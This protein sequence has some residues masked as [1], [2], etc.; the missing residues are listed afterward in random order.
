MN[1]FVTIL[2]HELRRGLRDRA[3]PWILAVFAVLAAYGAWSGAIWTAERA[4]TVAQVRAEYDTSVARKMELLAKAPP[5]AAPF[6]LTPQ[7]TSF[8]IALDPGALSPLSIGQAEA[9]PYAARFQPLGDETLFDAFKVYVDNPAVRQAGRL[10][11]A[12]VLVVLAPLL[13]LAGCYDLWN[14]ERESGLSSLLLAQP[15]APGLLLAAKALARALLILTPMAGWSMAVLWMAQG[16]DAAGLLTL[17]LI[18]FVYGA[19]WVAVALVANLLTRRSTEAAI[20]CGAAWIALVAVGP[21][22]ALATVNLAAPPP[23]QARLANDMRAAAM[24]Y[25]AEIAPRVK[26]REAAPL[27]DPPPA[28][29]DRVRSF[30]SDRLTYQ[31]RMAPRLNAHRAQ[32][33][34]HRAALDVV[35]LLLAPVAAQDAL[36]RLA[37]SDADRAM[38][39]QDQALAFKRTTLVWLADRL[40]ADAIMTPEDY[41]KV[42]AFV[43]AEP[44]APRAAHIVGD[45]ALIGLFTVALAGLSAAILARRNLL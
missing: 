44:R 25:R 39:F 6:F 16:R 5:G 37:G 38:A 34:R 30:M 24:A 41:G 17:G 12:F 26:A 21:A 36:D 18:V 4:Q 2:G 35:R 23:S 29:P 3:L 7:T 19:F 31:A 8:H 10:D 13:V 15:V 9:Y 20:A 1:A 14:R 40:A 42:P 43:F 33:D 27:R 11:L 28:I 22:L 32:Q 45:L